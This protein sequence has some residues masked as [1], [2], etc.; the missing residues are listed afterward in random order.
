MRPATIA[1]ALR[2]GA[3]LALL[4]APLLAQDGGGFFGQG[5]EALP[6]PFAPPETAPAL[7]DG[8]VVAAGAGRELVAAW[9]PGHLDP[10]VS[11][12]EGRTGVY[13]VAFD[14]PGKRGDGLAMIAELGES[15]QATGGAGP[16]ASD[17]VL[18]ALKHGASFARTEFPDEPLNV[19]LRIDTGY[20]PENRGSIGAV[21]ILNWDVFLGVRAGA[22]DFDRDEVGRLHTTP[23]LADLITREVWEELG[24]GRLGS[25]TLSPPT[26]LPGRDGARGAL[27]LR[28]TTVVHQGPESVTGSFDLGLWPSKPDPDSS[29]LRIG[30][31]VSG[32]AKPASARTFFKST[33]LEIASDTVMDEVPRSFR[34]MWASLARGDKLAVARE[35]PLRIFTR[36]G[37]HEDYR[38]PDP[39]R[40]YGRSRDRERDRA[41][42]HARNGPNIFTTQV[43]NSGSAR[44]GGNLW[45]DLAHTQRKFLGQPTEGA[46]VLGPVVDDFWVREG[47]VGLG[48]RWEPAGGAG[49]VE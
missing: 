16:L 39:S 1:R 32:S 18:R 31:G 34:Q 29:L 38:K 6:D 24:L 44:S 47:S 41:R 8:A 10:A 21:R 37:W 40:K 2:T 46:G 45:I 3:L 23:A 48:V 42:R 12:V 43:V 27:K 5:G 35:E 11:P 30:V 22:V 13:D 15:G 28:Y 33:A 17:E 49:G 7:G 26:Y 9:V 4:A 20:D 19:L 36:K 25:G 14:V